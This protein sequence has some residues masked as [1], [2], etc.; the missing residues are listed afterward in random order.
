M[1][2]YY[3]YETDY[4]LA[5]DMGKR[6]DL[7]R[8]EDVIFDEDYVLHDSYWWRVTGEVGETGDFEL[9]IA[10]PSDPLKPRTSVLSGDEGRLMVTASAVSGLQF[11]D[12]DLLPVP[13]PCCDLI[14][15]KQ[16]SLRGVG[17]DPDEKVFGIFFLRYGS[18]G[19]PYYV[20]A[21]PEMQP[22]VS[23]KWLLSPDRDLILSWEPVDVADL[24]REYSEES[25]G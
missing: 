11:R 8:M 2:A 17:D 18:D 15:V 7:K 10:G 24:L 21:D 13:W 23:S 3:C 12:G 20:P 19:D 25:R 5:D 1:S 16:A 9:E 14:Y 6:L 22:G 4:E